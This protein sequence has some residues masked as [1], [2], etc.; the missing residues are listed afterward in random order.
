VIA[1]AA[2]P[3]ELDTIADLPKLVAAIARLKR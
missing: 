3:A 1:K 2:T